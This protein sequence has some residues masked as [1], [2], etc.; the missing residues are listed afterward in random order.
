MQPE[1][2]YDLFSHAGASSLFPNDE[3]SYDR[4]SSAPPI[5]GLPRGARD[6]KSSSTHG[7]TPVSSGAQASSAYDPGQA[8]KLWN[9]GSSD[10]GMSVF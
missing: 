2:E 7:G 6:M 5:Q 10:N 1:Y 4:S 9:N 3:A 8:W